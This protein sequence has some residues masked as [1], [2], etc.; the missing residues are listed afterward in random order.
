[1]EKWWRW[2]LSSLW[3]SQRWQHCSAKNRLL[4][5]AP[6]SFSFPSYSHMT[7]ADQLSAWSW[8]VV[9]QWCPIWPLIK[10]TV[11]GINFNHRQPLIM[12]SAPCSW[13]YSD[14]WLATQLT[15]WSWRNSLP[16]LGCS[17]RALVEMDL[18]FHSQ[19][20]DTTEPGY[21]WCL[22]NRLIDI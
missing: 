4:I 12:S 16:Q 6:D 20:P 11:L 10:Q 18:W 9:N 5:W 2:R 1:M 14:S 22:R 13:C 15:A 19:R 8:W 7:T 17:R 3:A 21:E